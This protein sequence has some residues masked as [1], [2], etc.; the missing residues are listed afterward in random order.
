MPSASSAVGVSRA[1]RVL[2]D[3]QHSLRVLV[4]ELLSVRSV[5]VRVVDWRDVG[6]RVLRTHP[7]VICRVIILSV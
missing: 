3:V 5:F 4:G 1:G 7:V 6:R 2:G